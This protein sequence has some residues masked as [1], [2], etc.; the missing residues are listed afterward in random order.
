MNTK[1]D[2]IIPKI[3]CPALIL[4]DKRKDKVIGRIYLLSVSTMDKKLAIG[5]GVFSGSKKAV[6]IF[7]LVK[8]EIRINLNHIGNPILKVVSRWEVMVIVKGA[9]P[10]KFKIII[11]MNVGVKIEDVP[12]KKK[13]FVVLVRFEVIDTIGIKIINREGGLVQ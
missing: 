3:T 6:K 1:D 8:I 7:I 11:D 13:F 9:A 2:V 5:L 12:F 4:A 10:Y